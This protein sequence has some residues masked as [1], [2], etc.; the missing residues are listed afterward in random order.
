MD[1]TA[2]ARFV[3]AFAC[4]ACAVT[5][6]GVA[7]STV[8]NSALFGYPEDDHVIITQYGP[9]RYRPVTADEMARPY[10][11]RTAAG[12]GYYKAEV[13][14]LDMNTWKPMIGAQGSWVGRGPVGPGGRVAATDAADVSLG[15]GYAVRPMMT[16]TR[17][18]RH[19]YPPSPHH[20]SYTSVRLQPPHHRSVVAPAVVMAGRLWRF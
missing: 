1:H 20:R 13:I 2:V 17:R 10:D 12:R 8:T 7:A 18:R 19:D 5:A 14:P 9:M 4:V 15:V 6:D 11:G 16:A 3:V